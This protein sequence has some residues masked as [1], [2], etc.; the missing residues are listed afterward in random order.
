MAPG[1][2]PV[3]AV[4]G[5]Q[6]VDRHDPVRP[7]SRGAQ[8]PGAVAAGR[9]V[10]AGGGEAEPGPARRR[11][12]PA[13]FLWLLGSGRAQPCP[14]AWP[15]WSV[16][17]THHVVF[18]FR[19]AAVARSRA[20]QGSTGPMPGQLA[21]PV[22]QAGRGAQRDGQGDPPGEPARRAPG[23]ARARGAAR[24][25]RRPSRLRGPGAR[26]RES[27]PRSRSR[28]ARARSSSIPPSSPALLQLT[29]PRA[30]PLI[31]GQHL[32]RRQFPA[33]QRGVA[34][35]LRPP[36]H[37]GRPAPPSPAA[38]SPSPARPP[39]TARASAE[40]SEPGVS[41][42]ARPRTFAST[43]RA[44]SSARYWVSRT[45]SS[46][47]PRVMIPSRQRVQR[48]AEPGGQVPRHGQQPVGRGPGL[49]QRQGQLVPG[50]LV[51]HLRASAPAPAR[52]RPRGCAGTPPRSR[53]A[54][55]RPCTPRARSK[56]HT[57][58]TSS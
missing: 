9:A 21:G 47:L 7:G 17:V 42:P 48:A 39:C 10:P 37:P 26:G 11:P 25:R 8:P 1:L 13:R 2:V 40:R 23:R 5:V 38:P 3:L 43:A 33:H 56:A 4:P 15:C 52:S 41:R 46:A 51:H 34:G 12:G 35:V 36:L 18:G 49:A 16:T 14:T 30:D 22:G 19:A 54:C 24:R 44:S 32:I 31:R 50:E 55:G 27:L 20:S 57:S 58:P 53:P 45:I 6:G 29:R 28:N